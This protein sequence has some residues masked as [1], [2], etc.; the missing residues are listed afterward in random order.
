MLASL[1]ECP[2]CH[3]DVW[4]VNYLDREITTEI[5]EWGREYKKRW[6]VRTWSCTTCGL[7]AYSYGKGSRFK[8]DA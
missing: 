2:K 5:D 4:R 3:R 8:Y 6:Y 7:I 1:R